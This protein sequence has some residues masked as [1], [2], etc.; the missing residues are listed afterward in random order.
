MTKS[1][2]ETEKVEKRRKSKKETEKVEKVKK[3]SQKV[4][5]LKQKKIK[6]IRKLNNC[7]SYDPK[8]AVAWVT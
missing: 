4:K 5:R 7:K 3:D 2:K 8:E 6:L 1:K